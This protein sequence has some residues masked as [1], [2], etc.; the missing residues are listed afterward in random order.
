MPHPF[1]RDR[2]G[3]KN[4]RWC[5]LSATEGAHS[6]PGVQ[7]IVPAPPLPPAATAQPEPAAA[8]PQE[9]ADSPVA[10]ETSEEAGV[11]AD[12]AYGGFFGYAV[13]QRDGSVDI[14]EVR[15]DYSDLTLQQA[16][17]RAKL[18][19]GWPAEALALPEIGLRPFP[20]ERADA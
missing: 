8:P 11:M 14:E 3:G 4:C 19:A 6:G 17:T 20:Q 9:V 1:E 12:P 5:G 10:L 16:F 18:M 13:F 7:T 15:G 2:F